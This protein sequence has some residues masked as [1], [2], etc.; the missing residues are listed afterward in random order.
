[1]I[2]KFEAEDTYL[3]YCK[4]GASL[5]GARLYRDIAYDIYGSG[6]RITGSGIITS[7]LN[8]CDALNK[9][10]KAA[11]TDAL[12]QKANNTCEY[13]V[14]VVYSGDCPS[15][16]NV[17]YAYSTGIGQD[18]DAYSAYLEAYF[19]ASGG[20]QDAC[21]IGVVP[22]II[23][24]PT[25]KTVAAESNTSFLVVAG[26]SR[27]SYQWLYNGTPI[28]GET[29]ATLSLTSVQHINEGAYAC[30][31]S[32]RLATII[33]NP[34]NLY[35]LPVSPYFTTNLTTATE[36]VLVGANKSLT[37]A[38]GGSQPFAYQWYKNG[39]PI[40]GAIAAT[41]TILAGQETEDGGYYCVISNVAGTVTSNTRTLDFGTA[42][43]VTTQP[44]GGFLS[45]G[46]SI[47]L[48]VVAGG[49][50]TLTYQ[51]KK[52]GTNIGGATSSSYSI[53]NAVAGNSGEYTCVIT[54]NWG[55]AT[56]VSASVSV[57]TPPVIVTQP[58]N[59]TDAFGATA[60]LSIVFRG[61]KPITI[62]WYRNGVLY[63]T[64]N[65]NT[66]YDTDTI[67]FQI[68]SL[69]VGNWYCVLSNVN[70]DTTSNTVTVTGEGAPVFT[71]QPEGAA[72]QDGSSYTLYSIATG[73][74]V[75]YQWY[76][77][78]SAISGETG[79]IYTIA[80]MSSADEGYYHVV[81]TNSR[82]STSSNSVQVIR[83]P[84]SEIPVMTSNTTPAG[85]AFSNDETIT[86]AW[87]A[88]DNYLPYYGASANQWISDILGDKWIGYKFA[89]AKAINSYRIHPP[90]LAIYGTVPWH[91][92]IY[93]YNAVF[94]ASN[95]GSS[96]T[97]LHTI[98]NTWLINMVRYNF[99]NVTSY[100]YYRLRITSTLTWPTESATTFGGAIGELQM[101]IV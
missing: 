58:S 21:G 18:V 68:N 87:K 46:G 100:L 65:Y 96:Y 15:D 98:T 81:A 99:S 61:Q 44:Q 90:T 86:P 13:V 84:V 8:Y 101:F 10:Y 88:F 11:K 75:T 26:G 71:Q 14:Q 28:A 73:G 7:Y 4:D 93:V 30:S 50:P 45:L 80:A 95:D 63:S 69:N 72:V 77:N 57:G 23:T 24:H 38:V 31:V 49:S 19:I 47:T 17:D 54:N 91:R 89:T 22:Y 78:G 59:V 36:Y 29:S 48:T 39:T 42:P 37:I 92:A 12:T 41:Y 94:E 5:T 43:S 56:T 20:L 55:T 83:D 66:S 74:T 27:I 79:Q 62:K 35:V 82:G 40:V 33:S 3:T 2:C 53:T 67:Q 25:D 34:G 16:S 32:N 97:T 1:M 6:P 70:G 9:A 60:T 76:L 85:V 51:W 64:T 52:D